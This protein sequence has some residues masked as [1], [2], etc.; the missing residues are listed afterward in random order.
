VKILFVCAGNTCRS[1]MAEALAKRL[2]ADTTSV[3]S[4]GMETADGMMATEEAVTVMREFGID[5]SAHRSR[6]LDRL[7]LADYD[8]IVALSPRIAQHLTL[9]R[10]V[11]RQRVRVLDIQDPYGRGLAAY[12]QCLTHLNYALPLLLSDVHQPPGPAL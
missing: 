6:V 9:A 3:E 5:I 7:N 1:P 11:L 2:L 8:L 12:R 10:N 4:A